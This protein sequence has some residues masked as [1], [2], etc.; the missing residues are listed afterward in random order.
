MLSIICL[1][2]NAQWQQTSLNN[3]KINCIAVSGNNIFAGSA[4]G[5]YSGVYFS[6]NNGSSWS[7]P[8]LT[9]SYVQILVINGSN[10]FA[11]TSDGLYLSSNNGNNWTSLN[12][13]LP[14]GLTVW[15]LSISGSN[16]FAS[17]ATY[18]G[19]SGNLFLSSNNGSS[20]TQVNNGLP[21]ACNPSLLALSGNKV[22]ADSY[23][24]NLYFSS[25]NGSIWT[26]VS[27]CGYKLAAIG[28]NIFAS[29][30]TGV[31]LSS[32]DG[33]SWAAVNNGLTDSTSVGDLVISGSNIFAGTNSG[34]FLSSDNGSNW[35]AISNSGLTNTSIENLAIN[36]SYIFAVIDGI[37]WK[38]PLS[39]VGIE[40]INNKE[41][42]IA[43]YPNPGTNSITVETPQKAL[44]EINN[45]Q[46]KQI[47]TIETRENK[48]IID[49]SSLKSEMYYIK[50][51]T[52]KGIAVK[53]FIKE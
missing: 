18:D 6:S 17:L 26:L 24:G 14:S 11:G 49:V 38:R 15:G 27:N 22:F 50:V 47:K 39:E 44:I 32:D 48:T 34:V 37:V 8:S 23:N 52:E 45:I 19:I 1:S 9:S 20:W 29:C 41:I 30:Y 7:A 40:S 5:G 16:I 10:I 42:N 28:N 35:T 12:N 13:G 33:N 2:I 53:K 4:W 31:H 3:G 46:G 43:V 21:S 36:G 51:K 25:N